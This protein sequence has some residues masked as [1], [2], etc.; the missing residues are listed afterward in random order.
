MLSL[1]QAKTHLSIGHPDEDSNITDDIIAA[2]EQCEKFTGRLFGS[3]SVL[4]T[5][6]C[7]PCECGI[8]FPIEPVQSV[9]S[10]K[11]LDQNN[12]LQTVAADQYRTWLDHSPPL[13]KFVTGFAYPT[14]EL[15]EPAPIKI[16]FVAGETDI[17]ATLRKAIQ[18]ILGYWYQFPGGEPSLG[19]LSR[20]LP[21]GAISLLDTLWT[22]AQ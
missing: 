9:T 21:A 6:T 10:V 8:R 3:R 1:A 12:V 14:L 18:V 15:S 16:E 5:V 13:L 20:G 2:R 19:H 7:W 4:L 22:G 17:P 11:Y